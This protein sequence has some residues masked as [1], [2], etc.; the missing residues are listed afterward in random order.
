[1]NLRLNHC[2]V[3]FTIASIINNPNTSNA[4]LNILMDCVFG[5]INLQIQN[6]QEPMRHILNIKDMALVNMT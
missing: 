6:Q 5:F 2:P 3:I 1:M 4:A